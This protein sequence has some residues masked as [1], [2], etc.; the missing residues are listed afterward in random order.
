[1]SGKVRSQLR[2]GQWPTSSVPAHQPAEL[3]D[4]ARSAA[5]SALADLKAA[6]VTVTLDKSG[7]A[8]FRSGR[9]PPP[10]A[11]LLIEKMGDAVEALLVEQAIAALRE[12]A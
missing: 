5:E 3:T 7:R 9:I 2:F 8:R 10:A 1:M 6:G 11:R 4:R 12:T